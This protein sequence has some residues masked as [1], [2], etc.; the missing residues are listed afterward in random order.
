MFFDIRY[1]IVRSRIISIVDLENT[2]N[3][4]LQI[5]DYMEHESIDRLVELLRNHIE[6]SMTYIMKSRYMIKE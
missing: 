1:Q 5:L 2:I 6:D 4:H 3:Q